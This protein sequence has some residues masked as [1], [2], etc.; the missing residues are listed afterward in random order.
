MVEAVCW[1]NLLHL[2]GKAYFEML[3]ILLAKQIWLS[4]P[5]VSEEISPFEEV[6]FD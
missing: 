3:L 4:I 2:L 1:R 6:Y 5:P